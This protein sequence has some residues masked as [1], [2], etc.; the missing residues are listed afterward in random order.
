MQINLLLRPA[1]LYRSSPAA[2]R[3]GGI[4][5]KELQPS[6]RGRLQAAVP[7]WAQIQDSRFNIK[8]VAGHAWASIPV[9]AAARCALWAQFII[10]N[11]RFKISHRPVSTASVL[12]AAVPQPSGGPARADLRDAS[13]SPPPGSGCGL[14]VAVRPNLLAGIPIIS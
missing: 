13:C 10:Q 3:T 9:R 4:D 1:Y 2:E 7:I 6:V 8:K 5:C 11:S 14:P 12:L